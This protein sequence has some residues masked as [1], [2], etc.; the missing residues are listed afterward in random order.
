MCFVRQSLLTFCLSPSIVDNI[1]VNF[2]DTTR[3]S[4]PLIDI[5]AIT[6][7]EFVVITQIFKRVL[8]IIKS[9]INSDYF[10]T[11]YT[12]SRIVNC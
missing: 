5:I 4:L 12:G 7:K 3:N 6:Y 2:V 11:S 8:Y 10:L 9:F 1:I